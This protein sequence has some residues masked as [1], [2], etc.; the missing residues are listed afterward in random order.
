MRRNMYL[1]MV[2]NKIR[3]IV[4][5]LAALLL[6]LALIFKFTRKPKENKE[7]L[8]EETTS[9]SS[10][11]VSEVKAELP[12]ESEP[13]SESPV[14]NPDEQKILEEAARI[15]A[16]TLLKQAADQIL[17][18]GGSWELQNNPQV[19]ISFTNEKKCI[20]T[21]IGENPIEKKVSFEWVQDFSG[22]NGAYGY[23]VYLEDGHELT[24][25]ALPGDKYT[26]TSSSFFAELGEHSVLSKT[27][28]IVIGNQK[29]PGGV[30]DEELNKG[31]AKLN[32]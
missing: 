6:I 13:E 27:A 28:R 8:L 25:T 3:F 2:G 16:Q 29:N 10:E 24:I 32:G 18:L 5:G 31:G 11:V 4:L 12:L 21:G 22:E 15:E 20:I 17:T 9:F 23:N 30:T 7:D 26:L 19:S 1:P 14:T